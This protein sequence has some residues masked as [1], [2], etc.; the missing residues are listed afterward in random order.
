M[1]VPV[2]R[3]TL[4]DVQYINELYQLNIELGRRC[5]NGPKKYRANY[6]DHIIKT[7]L[8]A[9]KYAQ[10]ANII[11]IA[12]NSPVEMLNQRTYYLNQA[13]V[14]VLDIATSCDIFFELMRSNGD[15]SNEKCDKNEEIIGIKCNHIRN[16]IMGVINH[17][18]NIFKRGQH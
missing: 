18:K 4:S 13:I 3:R 12:P 11:Y 14:C 8:E 9:L 5:N 6:Y 1:S 16:L 15:I 2:H 17:D 7:G 10:Q